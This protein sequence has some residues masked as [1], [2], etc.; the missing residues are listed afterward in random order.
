MAA[1][2]AYKSLGEKSRIGPSENV[3]DRPMTVRD[4]RKAGTKIFKKI[5]G[6]VILLLP[7]VLS[8]WLSLTA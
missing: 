3:E 7:C 1:S 2:Q 4:V 6:H 5:Q 8:L